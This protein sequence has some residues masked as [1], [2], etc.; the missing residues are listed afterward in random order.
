MIERTTDLFSALGRACARVL[1]ARLRGP[2]SLEEFYDSEWLSQ[3]LLWATHEL[4]LHM[5]YWDAGTRDHAQSL[6]RMR[7]ELASLVRVAAGDRVLDAGCGVG[8]SALWLA[9]EHGVSVVGITTSRVQIEL[10]RRYATRRGLAHLTAFEPRDLL[11]TGY[12]DRHFDLVWAQ[13]S[14][15]QVGDHRRFLVEA[16]RLLRP[17]G[18]LLVEEI[19][20]VSSVQ[21]PQEIALVDEFCQGCRTPVPPDREF[22]RWAGELGFEQIALRDISAETA[23]SF[24]RMYRLGRLTRPAYWLLDSVGLRSEV[25]RDVRRGLVAQRRAFERGLLRMGIFTAVKPA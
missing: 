2:R 10:A 14:V 17:G 1:P 22:E 24:E 19:F 11:D 21:D 15:A 12:P 4:A 3:R 23:P 25:Q 20:R 16:E 6:L 8:G 5:G 7:Q 13:E 18:R 9:R